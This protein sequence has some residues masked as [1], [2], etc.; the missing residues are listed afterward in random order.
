MR[1]LLVAL[2][3][4]FVIWL[5]PLPSYA[6]DGEDK[7][8]SPYFF[9]T[10]DPEIDKLPLKDTSVE[11]AIAGVIADVK[12]TQKYLNAGRRP[13]NAT[14]VFPAS[15][16]AAVYSMRMKIGNEVIVA[17]I[18]ERERARKQFE[19]AKAAGKSTSLLEQERPNVFSM[20]MANLMPKEEIEIELR[21]TEL[22]VPTKGVYE[23]VYPTVVGP[24]YRSLSKANES[25]INTKHFREG[26][27]PTSSLHINAVISTGLP[28]QNLRSASHEIEPTY[29]NA[30]LAEFKLVDEKP[31]EGNR[32]FI[33]RYSLAGDQ[34]ESGM[35]LFED[36]EEK[37]FM[38][39]AQPPKRVV[40]DKIPAREYV[41]V[42]DVSGSM[43]GFPLDT[44]KRLLEDLIG[45][46]RP[47]DYFN[48]VLFAGDSLELSD[49]PLPANKAN[50]SRAIQL[51]EEQ[52]G[53]GGTELLE[54]IK[55]ATNLRTRSGVSRSIVVVTDGYIE[56]E[57]GVFQYIRENLGEANVFSFGIGTS[58]NRHLIEGI[59]KSG[60]GEPFVVTEPSRAAATATNFREYIQSPLL[61]DVS[62]NADGF[63]AY[64]VFPIR[65]PDLL[66]ERP[67][68]VFG[69]WRGPVHGSIDLEGNNGEGRF[70]RKF[71]ISSAQPNEANRALKYLWARSRIS[72][73]SDYGIGR[74]S[75]ESVKEITEL[76]LKYSLLTK[77]TSFI[78]VREKVVNPDGSA[79]DVNQ[80]LPLP[81]GVGNLAIGHEP[82]IFLLISSALLL[83]GIVMAAGWISG[84][85]QRRSV[86]GVRP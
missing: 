34:I 24:R 41:F 13:I 55:Q 78:A 46:L 79:E 53:Y 28:I 84:R 8:L 75:D 65:Q 32:D 69:K 14:Y 4:G 51:I 35:L 25:G 72:E 42:V 73:L 64:D 23:L 80:Q 66:A 82:E 63:R 29:R 11:I 68:I 59:A 43:E 33:L 17:K 57:E 18:K 54:A 7:T 37:F 44:S 45:R 3:S 85:K 67:V 62:V 61:T 83:A 71:D 22:L 10:G 19:A 47:T 20:K 77:Y 76:G 2:L 60:Q 5:M 1:T 12:V 49:S 27:Q 74:I 48:V 40:E 26:K 9:V 21:Y 30:N 58:V 16:R 31:F 6:N 70:A 56:A 39:M 36:K 50:I 81:V 38:Y 86:S 52:R 15:T